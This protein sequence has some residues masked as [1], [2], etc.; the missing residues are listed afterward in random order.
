MKGLNP[1]VV[2]III[3]VLAFIVWGIAGAAFAADPMATCDLQ[4]GPLCFLWHF[5]APAG[6]IWAG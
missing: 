2:V 6:A 4:V 5:E 1:G 3:F